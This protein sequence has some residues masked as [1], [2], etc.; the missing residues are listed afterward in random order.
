MVDG[1]VTILEIGDSLGVDLGYGLAWALSSDAQV[2]LVQDA[3]VDSGLVNPSFYD[4]PA[5]LTGEL[6][7]THP[8]IVVVFLGANDTAGVSDGSSEAGFGTAAWRQ[9]YG[10]RVSR[11]MTEATSVGAKV[12]W[13]GMPIMASSSLSAKMQTV[14]AVFRSEAAGHRG[15]TYFSSWSLFA[16]PDGRYDAGSTDVA[17]ST[18][19]LRDEDGVHLADGGGDLLGAALV[20]EMREIYLLP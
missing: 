18:M 7:A 14:D 13:V 6:D 17:G 4:W 19:R 20:R 16:T 10:G 12:L 11:I 15:V 9:V 2:N 1:K 5:E 8:Q 3:K